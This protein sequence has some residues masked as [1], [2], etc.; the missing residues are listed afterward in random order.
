MD[1]QKSCGLKSNH[2]TRKWKKRNK[3]D[4]PVGR[5]DKNER[6]I[7]KL[8]SSNSENSLKE[9]TKQ[10]RL[11]GYDF[12][13]SDDSSKNLKLRT[14]T[15]KRTSGKVDHKSREGWIESAGKKDVVIASKKKRESL[16]ETS[17]A[18]HLTEN[19]H[20]KNEVLLSP[21]KKKKEVFQS[22][23]KRSDEKVPKKS[24]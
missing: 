9:L 23:F 10:E 8:F 2:W 16:P 19:N 15:E 5:K 14:S 21:S 13:S 1:L 24:P 3:I 17:N 7:S 4:T 12:S 20:N 22:N 11:N 18:K 6:P